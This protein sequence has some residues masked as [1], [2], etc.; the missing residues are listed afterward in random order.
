MRLCCH[1]PER[2]EYLRGEQAVDKRIRRRIERCETL[3]ECG[4]GNV[5]LRV[6]YLPEDLQQIE[7]YVRRPADDEHKDN[8]QRHLHGLDLGP[9]YDA[10]GAGASRCRPTETCTV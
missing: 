1:L 9:W 7:Y 2:A 5:G 8:R 4:D 10:P 6:R 3:N